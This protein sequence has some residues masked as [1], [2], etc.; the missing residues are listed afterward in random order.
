MGPVAS[1]SRY[2]LLIVEDE[3]DLA[4]I[5]SRKFSHSGF[6]VV[7]SR[8]VTD[9]MVKLSNQKFDCILLDMRLE[10]GSGERIIEALKEA[11]E[12]FNHETPIVVMSGFLD[13]ELVKRI[14]GNVKGV[15][16]K[17][18]DHDTLITKVRELCV[19][20]EPPPATPAPKVK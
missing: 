19:P 14:R 9:S 11:K 4:K 13:S 15:L 20:S 17:P 2:W 10:H 1:E 8:T 6:R 18:F 3:E 16:V 12:G 7:T 5:L